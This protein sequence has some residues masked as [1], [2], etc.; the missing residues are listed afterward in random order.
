LI[1]TTDLRTTARVVLTYGAGVEHLALWPAERVIRS[2]RYVPDAS[3]VWLPQPRRTGRRALRAVLL[4]LLGLAGVAVVLGAPVLREYPA[5]L[6]QPDSVAGMPRLTDATHRALVD[7]MRT[8]IA[9]SVPLRSVVTAFYAPD[10]DPAREVLV[11]AGT[12]LV[13]DP[14]TQLDD[15]FRDLVLAGHP[16]VDVTPV[17]PGFLGGVARCA[18]AQTG[19]MAICGWVDHGSAGLVIGYGRGVPATAD[20]LRAIRPEI[21]HRH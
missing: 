6:S 19:A 21:L 4:V 9:A 17:D 8:R 15:A 5:T 1:G 13:L 14:G 18:A 7:G 11:V 16:V 2:H 3:L 10:A 20:L 12:R